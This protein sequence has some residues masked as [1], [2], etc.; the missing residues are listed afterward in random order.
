MTRH[1]PGVAEAEI[2]V[3]DP[4][5]VAEPSTPRLLGVDGETARPPEHPLHGD[6]G[7]QRRSS[8]LGE[9]ARPR[10]RLRERLQLSL[11]QPLGALLHGVRS[12]MP[13]GEPYSPSRSRNGTASNAS[14]PSTPVA[15]HV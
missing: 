15:D 1:R 11:E 6:A 9:S 5:D 4:V 7:E 3:L 2:D 14:G 12:S 13:W 10:V 8:P